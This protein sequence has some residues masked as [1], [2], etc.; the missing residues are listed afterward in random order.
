MSSWA[1]VSTLVGSCESFLKM[2]KREEIYANRYDNLERLPADIE[3]KLK[4]LAD[5]KGFGSVGRGHA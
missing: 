1:Q 3:E 5:A 4:I 2:L